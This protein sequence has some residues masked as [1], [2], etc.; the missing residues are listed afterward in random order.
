MNL[1]SVGPW[2]ARECQDVLLSAVQQEGHLAALPG[3]I[4]DL[5]DGAALSPSC[6]SIHT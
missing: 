2:K 1:G 5:A 6:A 3:L 4:Q